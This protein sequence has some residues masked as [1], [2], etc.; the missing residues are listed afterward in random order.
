MSQLDKAKESISHLKYWLGIATALAIAAWLF[1]NAQKIEHWKTA[2]GI[3]VLLVLFVS[4][5][6]VNK[7]IVD[8][9]DEL[10]DLWLFKTCCSLSPLLGYWLWLT[11]PSALRTTITNIS[12]QFACR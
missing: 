5:Y 12:H 3:M 11:V 9:I 1:D 4:V 10:G 2:V 6:V 8:K 7:R